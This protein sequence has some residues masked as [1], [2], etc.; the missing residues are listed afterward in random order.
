[1]RIELTAQPKDLVSTEGERETEMPSD[2]I[3]SYKDRD[4]IDLVDEMI[5]I[6]NDVSLTEE[7][8]NFNDD[9]EA[10]RVS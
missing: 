2:D 5:W 8:P 4:L 3:S 6:L 7:K 1:M 10:G 9:S